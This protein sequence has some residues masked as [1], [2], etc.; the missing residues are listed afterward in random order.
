MEM[1]RV[2]VWD[3]ILMSRALNNKLQLH[4]RLL[5]LVYS[6]LDLLSKVSYKPLYTEQLVR[7]TVNDT[8]TGQAAASPKAQIVW[9]SI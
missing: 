9:P 1:T 3:W 2:F 7:R 6:F 4:F 5:F 8:C